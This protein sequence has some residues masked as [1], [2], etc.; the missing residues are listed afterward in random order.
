MKKFA[1]EIKWG[2]IFTIA[3]LL[4]MVLEKALG[5]HDTHIDKHAI[6]TNFFA[7]IA[8]AIFVFALL[9]KRN[10]DLGGKMT[11]VQGFVSG[12]IISVIVAI[13]SPLSQYI[14]HEYIT[15]DYFQNAITHA[16]E[17]G[18]MTQENAETYFNFS[19]YRIL[20]AF[21]GLGSGIVTSAIVALFIRKK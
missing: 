19:S 2:I 13:L 17:N 1:T 5:W 15:P 20:A 18:G 9:E 8:I 21:G 11:W 3:S 6:Y 10:K 16:V 14:T 12:I 4:W 7:I